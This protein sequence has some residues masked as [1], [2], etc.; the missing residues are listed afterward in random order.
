MGNSTT[1]P[2]F[3]DLSKGLNFTTAEVKEWFGKFK[4]DFPE[5]NI[6]RSDFEKLYTTM[7]GVQGDAT[8]FCNHVFNQYDSDGN[9]FIDFREFVTT[10]SVATKGTLQ[11]KLVWAF[12]LYDLDGNGSLTE[13]EISNVLFAIYK[14]KGMNE[15][16]NEVKV[17][18]DEIFK[19]ADD[20]G[21]G[22]LS[23]DE[24]VKHASSS[25]HIK[26]LVKHL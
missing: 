25:E 15:A 7:I 16:R 11:E 8:E 1:K 3:K 4:K 12:N 26:Q 14:A 13:L 5:G 18:V 22:V 21:D 20:N 17:V 10:V 2:D 6:T 9:G 23:E 19:S 24:F